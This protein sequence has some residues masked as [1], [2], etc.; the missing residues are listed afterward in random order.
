MYVHASILTPAILLYTLLSS[1]TTGYIHDRY[2][3]A[4]KRRATTNADARRQQAS[5]I[6]QIS[7]SPVTPSPG[8]NRYQCTSHEPYG[9]HIGWDGVPPYSVSAQVFFARAPTFLPS[10]EEKNSRP[11]LFL[12]ESGD[13]AYATSSVF[14]LFPT[15]PRSRRGKKRIRF[16]LRFVHPPK[17]IGYWNVAAVEQHGRQRGTEV[18]SGLLIGGRWLERAVACP[19]PSPQAFG[20]EEESVRKLTCACVQPSLCYQLLR[21]YF[22]RLLSIPQQAC[23]LRWSRTDAPTAVQHHFDNGQIVHLLG[24]VRARRDNA[25]LLRLVTVLAC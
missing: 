23:G 6:G 10:F 5:S 1:Y 13:D 18:G 20:R 16:A 12:S 17:I 11:F 25:E 21:F 22:C 7:S 2:N 19:Q 24:R 8:P 3:A 9:Y 15:H 14:P 4:A